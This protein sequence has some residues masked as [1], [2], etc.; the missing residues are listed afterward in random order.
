MH[1]VGPRKLQQLRG[2]DEETLV[3]ESALVDVPTVV[4]CLRPVILLPVAALANLQPSH[5]EAILA[6]ELAHIRRHDY[7][8]NLLQTVAETVLFYHPGVWWLSARIREERELC[9]S[10]ER[11]GLLDLLDRLGL[12]HATETPSPAIASPIFH[13]VTPR[14]ARAFSHAA[15]CAAGTPTSSPPDVWGS[16]MSRCVASSTDF[17]NRT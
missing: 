8:V 1:A 4:G 14:A 10:R 2:R 16:S 7:I 3:V 5:I 15:A 9:R 13:A 11:L 6:H 12:G 17:A